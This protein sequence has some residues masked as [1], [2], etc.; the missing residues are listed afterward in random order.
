MMDHH[1]KKMIQATFDRYITWSYIVQSVMTRK[2]S[3]L[4]RLLQ[5]PEGTSVTA[6]MVYLGMTP[7]TRLA[8]VNGI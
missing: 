7:N 3:A 4:I 6:R 5:V 8:A 2:L 1:D